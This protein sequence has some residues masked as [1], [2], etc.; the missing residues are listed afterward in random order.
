MYIIPEGNNVTITGEIA[1]AQT[2]WKALIDIWSGKEALK[3]SL[4]EK[5]TTY[6]VSGPQETPKNTKLVTIDKFGVG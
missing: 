4:C 6:S 1:R 3:V 5:L 2:G